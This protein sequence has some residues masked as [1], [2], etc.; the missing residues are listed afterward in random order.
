MSTPDDE[1]PAATAID[2]STAVTVATTTT[3]RVPPPCWTDEETAAL[4][5][6]Y[7]D[8]WFALRRGNLRAAD[9]DDVAASLP[10]LGGPAKTAIQCRHKI[11]KLRKR[12]RGEKQRSLNKPGKFSSSWD[13]FPVL[14][15]MEFASVA[16]SPAVETYDQDVDRE[17]EINGVDGFRVRSKRSLMITPRDEFGVRSRVKM[18]GGFDSD[19]DSGGGYGLKRRYNAD[20]DDEILLAPKATRLRGSHGKLSSGE[21]S[22]GGGFPLKSYGDRSFASHGLKPKNFS[23]KFSPEMDY[24]DDEREGFEPRIHNSR[25]SSRVNG[26]SNPRVSSGYGSSSRSKHEE[27]NEPDPINEVVSSVKMLTEMFVRVEKSKM[28]MMREM[29]KTRMEM[30]LKHCQMMLESQ[31]QIIGAFTEALSEKKSTTSARR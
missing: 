6:A 28:E 15:A 20:S 23:N 1:S 10:T 21:F 18:C 12:Y 30:E 27:M 24:D 22:H 3:R 13:L 9:W 19:H 17:D 16:A 2:P 26:Y 14:D 4:V 8:K 25:S 29:E 5:D 7:K 31:Q 11:E